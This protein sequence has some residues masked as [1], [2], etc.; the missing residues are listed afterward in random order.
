MRTQRAWRLS[1]MVVLASGLVSVALPVAAASAQEPGQV[2]G[3]DARQADGF[4]TLGWEPVAGATD[5]QIERTPVDA[6]NVPTGPSVITGVWQPIRT[7]TPGSP[8]F[9]DAGFALGGRFQW[10]VRARFGTPNDLPWLT[11]RR[12]AAAFPRQAGARAS[13]EAI[14]TIVAIDRLIAWTA[15][16][17]APA[18]A[19][20]T[21]ALLELA[22]GDVAA[23]PEPALEHYRKAWA[24]V[25][26]S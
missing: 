11:P 20:R 4:T 14:E 3:L 15:I 22:R 10:R 25:R 7:V 24:F 18:G 26:E 17:E 13:D 19:D 16:D 23:N 6:S 5:Y 8:R 12:P 1:L 9:A 2:T 21:R